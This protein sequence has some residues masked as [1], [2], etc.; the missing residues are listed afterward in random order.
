VDSSSA[1]ANCQ[2]GIA[3]LRA[4]PRFSRS[5]RVR[6]GDVRRRAKILENIDIGHNVLHAQWDWMRNPDTWVMRQ[7]FFVVV[8]PRCASTR[9]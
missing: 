9:G 5:Y 3:R 2:N 1:A 8:S 4:G 6:D 7:G